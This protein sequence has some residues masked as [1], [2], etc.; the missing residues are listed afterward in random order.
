MSAS[1]ETG[2]KRIWSAYYAG[3]KMNN[4]LEEGKIRSIAYRLLNAVRANDKKMF[5][6]TTMRLYMSVEKPLPTVFMNVLDE[7]Q[8]DFASVGDSFVAGLISKEEEK[9]DEQ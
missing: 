8:I 7:T 9:K 3:I 5:L 2:K 6:D 4:E 1:L